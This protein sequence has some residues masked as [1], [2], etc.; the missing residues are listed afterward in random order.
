ML[1]NT[2]IMA[3]KTPPAKY[4]PR[5]AHTDGD[6]SALSVRILVV[7]DY[8]PLRRF[9]AS[10]LGKRSEWRIIA[11]VADGLEA[12]HKAEELQ[13]DLIL[14]D[15]GL[16]TLN[17]IEAARRIRSLSPKS[18]IL[19]VSQE[20]SADVVQEALSSKALGYVVKAHA[21]TELLAAVE[22]VL[23]GQQFIGSGLPGCNFADA[24]ATQGLEGPDNDALASLVTRKSEGTRNHE[25]QFFPDDEALL[26][27][28]AEVA[29]AGLEAGDAVIV[30]ATE[31]HRKGLLQRLQDQGVDCVAA[32]GQG[33]YIALDVAETLSSFMVNKL[34]DPAQFLTFATTTIAAG[35]KATKG[36]IHRV[37]ICGE[38]APILWAQGNADAAIQVER[39]AHEVARIYNVGIFCGYVLKSSQNEQERLFCERICNEHSVA[40][41]R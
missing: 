2:R 12:V 20:S 3:K 33:R 41:S 15:I 26:V 18:K 36:D 14:L 35:A 22:A 1:R 13:P 31:S 37:T 7:D 39:L 17:G 16:P 10:M 40:R 32:I 9:I 27:G 21:G 23:K 38:C 28:F 4:S 19:F 11:E 8:E 6:G 29:L 25:V 5:P 24:L 34:P 30:I